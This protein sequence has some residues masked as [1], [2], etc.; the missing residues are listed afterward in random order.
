MSGRG[1]PADAG[2]R[3][4]RLELA[5]SFGD[6]GT[7][8]PIVV[9][10]ILLN[11][12]SP[13]AVLLAF[14]LFYVFTGLFYR[15]PVPVQ[16][17]KAVAAIAIASPALV[18]VP[19]IAAAGILFGA[20]MLALWAFRLV[21]LAARLFTAPV[22]RGIQLAL[23]MIFLRKGVQLITSGALFVDGRPGPLAAQHLNLWLGVGV[24]ALVLALLGNARFPAALVALGVGL[25]AGYLGGG[26]DGVPLALGPTPLRIVVPEAGDFWT[27]AVLL[28]LPQIPLTIGNACVGTAVTAASLF[29]GDPRLDRARAGAFAFT[30]GVA[31]IPAGL[32][33]AVPM[34][35]GTGGLV[36]HHRFGARTGAAPVFLG[37]LLIATALGFGQLGFALLASIPNA[38][39]GVLLIFAG[40]ELC[41][42]VRSLK[43]N[44][45]YF[46]ALLITGIALA[47]PNMAWAFGAGILVDLAIRRFRITI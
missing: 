7:F 9:A 18:T 13:S 24:F 47:V 4:D 46:V 22:V 26:V 25:A 27:A 14:G 30:M 28:V 10:M 23:G 38:V 20:V 2:R 33:G 31:N 19:V 45:E 12:L 32:L 21:D 5:G 17:L 37:L 42:L 36:A 1:V 43:T 29:P 6:L 34:C 40:L 8:L 16:P 35:H 11:G 3:F 41:P 44:E 15:L 39:L